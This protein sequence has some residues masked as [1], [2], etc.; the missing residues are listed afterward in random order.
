[1]K[2]TVDVPGEE[3]SNAIR[4]TGAKTRREAVV[5]A[6]AD[7]NRRRRML[8]LVQYAG[9]CAELLTADELQAQRRQG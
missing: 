2:T 3:L 9:T 6:I 1:M 8:E 4:F 5:T 7:C